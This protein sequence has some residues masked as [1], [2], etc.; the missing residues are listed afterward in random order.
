MRPHVKTLDEFSMTHVTQ[1]LDPN[2]NRNEDSSLGGIKCN[3]V[4]PQSYCNWADQD[5]LSGGQF[6]R[7]GMA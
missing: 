4:G 5:R 2:F 6:R 1:G 3:L 7:A